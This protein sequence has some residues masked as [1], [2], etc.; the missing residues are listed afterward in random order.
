M[1]LRCWGLLLP[2]WKSEALGTGL[3][4]RRQ[5]LV[6]RTLLRLIE[7]ELPGIYRLLLG[8]VG[9]ALQL[10]GVRAVRVVLLGSCGLA[11]NLQIRKLDVGRC[12]HLGWIRN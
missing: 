7:R 8:G 3:A 11:Q 2:D 10:S 4:A 5:V 9:V 6:G 12:G 1:L